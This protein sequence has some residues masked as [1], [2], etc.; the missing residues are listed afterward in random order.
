[1]STDWIEPV[2]GFE[3]NREES[4][5]TK[6]YQAEKLA[7]LGLDAALFGD[8]VDPSFYIGIGINV[9]IVSGIS[10]EGN[11]NMLSRIVQ[12]RPVLLGEALVSKGRIVSVED[13]P[14]G[15]RI[16]TDVWFEG[17]DGERAVSVPRG[18]LKPDPSKA[19]SRG[20]GERP[21][22]VVENTDTLNL[23]SEHRLTPEGTKAYS[24]EGN[25]IHY[26]MEAANL[27]GFRA[28]IIG[29]GQGVHFLMAAIWGQGLEQ[30]DLDV[31]FR[32]PVFWDDTIAVGVSSDL[33]AVASLREGKV[34]TEMRVN[35]RR[36]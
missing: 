1:M 33:G 11:V 6:E 35:G 15:R 34:L 4:I 22:P 28:P 20:A 24:S 27:A 18:S 36:E 25:A 32:R 7:S 31:Y 17:S 19:G 14:R 30:V 23:V 8:Q 2:T 26:E 13:V 16:S 12:H 5:V 9:G 3:L 29:G 10:A 21:A